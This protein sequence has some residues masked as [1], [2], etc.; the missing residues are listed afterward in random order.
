LLETIDV[1]N[2]YITPIKSRIKMGSKWLA[3]EV[4]LVC[5]NSLRCV[6]RGVNLLLHL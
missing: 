1:S 3:T 6:Q 5:K 4:V 2:R